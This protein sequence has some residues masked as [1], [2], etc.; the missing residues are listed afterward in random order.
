M[1]NSVWFAPIPT[2]Y[3]FG[4]DKALLLHF[5]MVQLD[6]I[7]HITR[8]LTTRID[9]GCVYTV[10]IKVRYNIDSFTM[11]GSQF[12]FP[13]ESTNNIAS[14]FDIVNS[15]L[16]EFLS[17]YQGGNESIVYVQISF[18]KLTSKL[19]SEFTL[20]NPSHVFF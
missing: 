11:C 17:H 7:S 12:G 16:H 19:L 18:R 15:R 5:H 9:K 1:V 6:N 4:K 20:E 10:F 14:L 2:K 8:K 13:Y 3:I